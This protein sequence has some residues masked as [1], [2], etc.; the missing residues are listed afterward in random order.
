[1]AL[2]FRQG[3]IT[4]NFTGKDRRIFERFLVKLSLKY[5]RPN[6]NRESQAQTT[7]ASANG[8][9][10][11]AEERLSI[12]TPLKIW[13]SIPNTEQTLFTRGEVVW[14]DA[15]EENKYRIGV[16]LEKTDLM[17]FSSVLRIANSMQH[18]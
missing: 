2:L 1:M 6:P 9:G 11:S 3:G 17:A 10:I 16:K 13:L 15:I 8:I 18:N 7:D 12:G 14:S 4:Q 5:L